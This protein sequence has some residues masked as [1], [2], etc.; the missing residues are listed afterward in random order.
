MRINKSLLAALAAT[1]TLGSCTDFINGFDETA[2]YYQ[3]N[4]VKEFG[5]IDPNQDW[6]AAGQFVAEANMAKNI[7]GTLTIYTAA[8][9]TYGS[10]I[11]ARTPIENGVATIKF[12]AVK[13]TK[14]LYARVENDGHVLSS[15]IYDVVDGVL[16]IGN[17]LGTRAYTSEPCN[18]TKE[19]FTQE[20]RHIKFDI[21]NDFVTSG[22]RKYTDYNTSKGLDN[23]S[24]V[25]DMY[26]NNNNISVMEAVPNLYLLKN[27][28][29]SQHD[30][31]FTEE[32][33]EPI[34]GTYT[35]KYGETK[36]GAFQEGVNHIEQYVRTG[37]MT[38]DV[39]LVVKEDGPVE[40]DLMWRGTQF[41]DYFGYYYYTDAD[42]TSENWWKNVDKYI[43]IN[44][45]EKAGDDNNTVGAN[46]IQAVSSLTQRMDPTSTAPTTYQNVDGMFSSNFISW[47]G[48]N[49]VRGTKLKLVNFAN[50]TASYNFDAGTKIGF[51]FVNLKDGGG[52]YR[53]FVSDTDIDYEMFFHQ[54]TPSNAPSGAPTGDVGRGGRPYAAKFAYDGR[55]YVGFG[56]ECND[57]DLNDIV[58]IASN[59]VEPPHDITPPDLPEPLDASW[60]VACEDLGASDDIDF[61]DVVFKITHVAGETKANIYP[62]AAGGWLASEIMYNGSSLGEVHQLLGAAPAKSG[63]YDPINA[64]TFSV[65]PRPITIDVPNDFSIASYVVGKNTATDNGSLAGLSIKTE[66]ESTGFAVASKSFTFDDQE[67]GKVP[68]AIVI[69]STYRRPTSEAGKIE[70]GDWPWPKERVGIATAFN[71]PNHEFSSWV[72]NADNVDWYNYFDDSKVVLGSRAIVNGSTDPNTPITPET[73]PL[74]DVEIKIGTKTI[75]EGD[76]YEVTVGTEITDLI[77]PS[78]NLVVHS[79]HPDIAA[80]MYNG[81]E[82]DGNAYNHNIKAKAVG[83]ATIQV[84]VA[85]DNDHSTTTKSFTVKVVEQ[86]STPTNSTT[87][88]INLTECS[89]YN[90]YD[91]QGTQNSWGYAIEFSSVDFTDATKVT[92][93]IIADQDMS[94]SLQSNKSWSSCNHEFVGGA[95]STNTV[96]TF[97]SVPSTWTG[98]YFQTNTPLT[99]AKAVI[100]VIK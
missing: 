18:V 28:D 45:V 2:H 85:G 12:D 87:Y 82:G 23:S 53:F 100:T 50:G 52:S 56:D 70:I 8:P 66:G 34:F 59:V 83:E 10:Q 74:W 27:V 89:E 64:E 78:A 13:N 42:L 46:W 93:Q 51:F 16:R 21:I 54:Y 79:V 90:I 6:N 75:N 24:K 48:G 37:E 32:E 73:K 65:K 92:L 20:V 14:S 71:E 29:F 39:T 86:G 81:L 1:L 44:T 80:V 72:N 3:E 4:F 7:S 30:D 97:N 36:G 68:Q 15:G 33:L 88:D 19:K 55:T 61:N 99:N 63:E 25:V 58:F 62:L 22:E 35:N 94:L 5:Q 31:G 96:L 40:L 76:V 43:L 69:P 98:V 67:I 95:A 84:I 9:T 77:L 91:W 26:Q 38:T 41:N 11:L 17:N 47:Q 57:C 60:M 49:K